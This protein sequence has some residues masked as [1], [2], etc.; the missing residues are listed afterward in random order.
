MLRIPRRLD[1][2][3]I[4]GGKV[5]SPN[6]QKSNPPPPYSSVDMT[7][8]P[9]VRLLD[10][11]CRSMYVYFVSRATIVMHIEYTDHE[12]E[13]GKDVLVLNQLCITP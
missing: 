3:L 4:D 12:K 9:R 2:R 10:M 7:V 13:K 5:V 1:N 6:E 11:S 8:F